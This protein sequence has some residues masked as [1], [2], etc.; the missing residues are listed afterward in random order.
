MTQTSRALRLTVV[1]RLKQSVFVFPA[2]SGF[3]H[4][5]LKAHL[6]V[7]LPPL[8]FVICSFKSISVTL[9]NKAKENGCR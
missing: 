6:Y 5:R 1:N 7:I 3:G 8:F 2:E 9:W 4:S